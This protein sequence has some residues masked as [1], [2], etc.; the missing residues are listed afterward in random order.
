VFEK[1]EVDFVGPINT[2]TRISRARYIITMTE[3]LTRWDEATTMKDCSAE[4]IAH[5]LFEHIV[6]RFRCPRILMSDQGTHL[7]N[8]TIWAML[9]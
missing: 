3:Y 4:T 9:E 7:I 8:N 1:W 2:P 5:F 6:T